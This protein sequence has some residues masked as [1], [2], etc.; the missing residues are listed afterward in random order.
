MGQASALLETDLSKEI[1]KIPQELLLLVGERDIDT[2]PYCAEEMCEKIPNNKM[3]IFKG[4]GHM[5]DYEIPE[6]IAKKAID[7]LLEK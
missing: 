4:M 1:E 5:I 2:P 3:H 6:K 7:F